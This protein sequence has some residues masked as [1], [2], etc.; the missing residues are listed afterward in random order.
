MSSIHARCGE[1][2]GSL[3][4]DRHTFEKTCL[5]E[6][7]AGLRVISITPTPDLR[8][9]GTYGPM[10]NPHEPLA[11]WLV[12]RFRIPSHNHCTV[13]VLY[14]FCRVD[15]TPQLLNFESQSE[16]CSVVVA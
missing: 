12:P 2:Q 3:E 6:L 5:L 8:D 15:Q 4:G 16:P 1:S 14:Y 7:T 10:G 13:T 9:W 11:R